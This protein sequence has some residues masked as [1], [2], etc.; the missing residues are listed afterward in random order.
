MTVFQDVDK[1]LI[2]QAHKFS[3]DQAP[4]SRVPSR[5][6]GVRTTLNPTMLND[7]RAKESGFN[8]T[9]TPVIF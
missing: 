6:N 2:K 7:L 3:F 4:T 5:I 9:L 1:G 8:F